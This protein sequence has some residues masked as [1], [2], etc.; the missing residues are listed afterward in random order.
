MTYVQAATGSGGWPMSVFSK[1]LAEL[2]FLVEH[3]L[4][5]IA[6]MASLDSG[7]FFNASPQRGA[8]NTTKS[9]NPARSH[10]AA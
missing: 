10:R 7:Q 2:P 9:N 5:P 4:L 6:V 8:S 1:R 3:I